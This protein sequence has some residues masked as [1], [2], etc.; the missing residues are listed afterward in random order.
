MI[1][2]CIGGGGY[3]KG[4][5]RLILNDLESKIPISTIAAKYMI[6]EDAIRK[7]AR[8]YDKSLPPRAVISEEERKERKR[9]ADMRRYKLHKDRPDIPLPQ[10]PIVAAKLGALGSLN[11][12]W[13]LKQGNKRSSEKES[14]QTQIK[15]G[16]R[17]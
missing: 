14:K 8:K 6:S 3:M 12:S 15:F 16:L 9:Q 7:I 13:I 1:L 4:S 10:L 2:S 5:T 17:I 11:T